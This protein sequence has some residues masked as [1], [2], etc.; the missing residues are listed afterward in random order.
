MN[1]LRLYLAL[2]SQK[3][4]CA[5]KRNV[6]GRDQ[7]GN[8]DVEGKVLLKCTLETIGHERM[9][10]MQL[11]KSRKCYGLLFKCGFYERLNNYQLDNS[12]SDA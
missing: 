9:D 8:I 4:R 11:A 10:W 12:D 1:H 3:I 5:R 2:P 7:W 6:T